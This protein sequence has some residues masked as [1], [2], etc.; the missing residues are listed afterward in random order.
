MAALEH[1]TPE[2]IAQYGVIA[3]PDRLTGRADDNKK[4]FDRLV[5]ELVAVVVNEIIDKTNEL[6]V[7]ESVR[8]K[9]EE[10]RVAAEL[11]RVEAENLRVQ[12]ESQRVTNED[13]RVQAE[14]ARVA[15]E[16]LRVQ[17][18]N[19]RVSAE[20]SRVD[21]EQER[22]RAEAERESTT[23]GIVT[24]AT[25][26]ANLAAQSASRASDYEQRSSESARD[27][28][29]SESNARSYADSARLSSISAGNSETKAKESEDNAKDSAALAT[30]ALGKGPYVDQSTKTWFVWDTRVGKFVDT[31]IKAEGKDGST[32]SATGL[33][34][35]N[36]DSN[37][38][39]IVTYVGDNPPP[40]SLDPNG[41]LIYT[42]AG[43]RIVIG[44]IAGGSIDYEKLENLPTLNGATFKGNVTLRGLP[45][46]AGPQDADKVPTV[47]PDGTGYTLKTPSGG[48]SS[49]EVIFETTVTGL[50]EYRVTDIDFDSKV[51]TI[52]PPYEGNWG[53]GALTVCVNPENVKTFESSVP[54]EIK[55][56]FANF[57]S[58]DETLLDKTHIQFKDLTKIDNVNLD[59]FY[60]SKMTL[61][62]ASNLPSFERVRVCL[63]LRCG[64]VCGNLGF[65]MDDTLIQ[66]SVYELAIKSY[67]NWVNA[68][69]KGIGYEEILIEG[70]AI[71]KPITSYIGANAVSGD[72]SRI[73]SRQET[74]FLKPDTVFNGL[75]ITSMYGGL[76]N[77]SS[78]KII[79]E[80]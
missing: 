42:L 41:D 71:Y 9:N 74:F 32:I 44:N 59:T 25:E 79:K 61:V 39:L 75:R 72:I 19:L 4:I 3:A 46:P 37:G 34:G 76:V 68:N 54:K 33:W 38:D 22:E 58:W 7:D 28:A 18:E 27:A 14:A 10:E 50:P 56:I 78:V 23:R 21:A 31:G 13:E 36:V 64:G 48:G 69:L 67:T 30:D 77:G 11:L 1:I 55:R 26:Q 20:Q 63:D 65:K 53:Y 5:R 62:D 47:K 15:A 16:T 66:S 51:I 45:D 57:T 52:D 35:V 6:L 80:R 73:D 24:Q 43:N 8:E 12:A 70:N 2:Q 17:A 60:L 40:L 29:D 49:G